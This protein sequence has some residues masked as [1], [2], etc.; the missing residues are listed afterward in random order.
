MN[1]A[2]YKQYL[3]LFQ[4]MKPS[5]IPSD[6]VK[7]TILSSFRAVQNSYSSTEEK[8]KSLIGINC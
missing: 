3:A 5:R 2:V 4:L 1:R 6:T 7:E 8:K